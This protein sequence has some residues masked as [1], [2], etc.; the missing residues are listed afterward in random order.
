MA[1][2]NDGRFNRKTVNDVLDNQ[3]NT[4]Y[5]IDVIT[6]MSEAGTFDNERQSTTFLTIKQTQPTTA[7]MGV[8]LVYCTRGN[9]EDRPGKIVD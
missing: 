8:G 7:I 5:D 1:Q 3:T 9:H 4:A 6:G 2:P